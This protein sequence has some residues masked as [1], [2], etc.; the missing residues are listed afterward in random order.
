M[1]EELDAELSFEK[2]SATEA[3][4]KAVQSA[5]P[6]DLPG[7]CGFGDGDAYKI[8]ESLL[9]FPSSIPAAEKSEKTIT[10]PKQNKPAS[11][12]GA[13][14][15][16]SSSTSNILLA[17]PSFASMLQASERS[18]TIGDTGCT[19]RLEDGVT[20]SSTKTVATVYSSGND[21]LGYIATAEPL[22]TTRGLK[23]MCLQHKEKHMPHCQCWVAFPKK[24]TIT[25]A[26]RLDLFQTLCLW[27]ADGQTESRESHCEFSATIRMAAGMQPRTKKE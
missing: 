21:R 7:D 16:S 1:C 3:V 20:V 19:V 11:S 15:S 8:M 22:G 5:Q 17:Q 26:E 14:S 9:E 27:I 6:L 4:D 12:S 13:A 10:K 2:D 24:K 25:H 18:F 23:A